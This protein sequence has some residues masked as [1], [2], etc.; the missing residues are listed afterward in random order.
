MLTTNGAA[1]LVV[2]AH[3]SETTTMAKSP[4]NRA[5]TS[6]QLVARED[7]MIE[8]IPFAAGQE[9][10]GI[11]DPEQIAVAHR[12]G[13]IVRKADEAAAQKDAAE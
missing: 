11:D 13:R 9:I 3:L 4:V 1:A 12:L 5:I 10:T 6:A 7:I 2:A 8:G